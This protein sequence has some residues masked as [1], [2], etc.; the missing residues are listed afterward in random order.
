M[1]RECWRDGELVCFYSY[2]VLQPFNKEPIP[3][4]YMYMGSNI[5]PW[6]EGQLVGDEGAMK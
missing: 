2:A 5:G 1:V 3:A 6:R 4:E